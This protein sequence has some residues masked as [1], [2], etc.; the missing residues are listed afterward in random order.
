MK[1]LFII[2]ALSGT[3]SAGIGIKQYLEPIYPTALRGSQCKEICGTCSGAC[4]VD[5]VPKAE[6]CFNGNKR[7][8]C[9]SWCGNE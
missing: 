7:S 4:S 3:L 5:G 1:T 6:S 2:L 9:C 8:N